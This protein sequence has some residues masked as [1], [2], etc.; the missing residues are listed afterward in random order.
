MDGAFPDGFRWGTATAAHQIEGGNWNND[1]WA[2]EH[3]AGSGCVE[4][5]GDACDSWH[6]WADDVALVAGLGLRQLPVLDRVEPHRAGRGRVVDGR[7]S[8]TTGSIGEALLRTGV[9]PVVT[10]HHFT[11]PALGRRRG[12][13]AGPSRRPQTRSLAF[14]ERAAAALAPVL[15]RA[16]TINEP[17]IVATAGYL[18]GHVPARPADVGERRTGERACSSTRT[19]RRS[20]RSAAARPGC[21]SGSRSS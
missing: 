4:P 2:W 20:T 6:R 5:S 15:Q 21:R 12:R 8:T 9:D 11:T 19:A 17:N 14:C 3:T 18:L 16:C 13:L 10:F 7:R 1:W